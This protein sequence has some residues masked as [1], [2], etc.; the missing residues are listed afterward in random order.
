MVG[1]FVACLVLRYA[2]ESLK[3]K[4]GSRN[5]AEFDPARGVGSSV[6][7]RN[8]ALGCPRYRRQRELRQETHA[9]KMVDA[10]PPLFLP[11]LL[12][13]ERPEYS[14]TDA[15]TPSAG[16]RTMSKGMI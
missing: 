1:G 14:R 10:P 9:D 8:L 5:G 7:M 6:T 15:T 3:S 2:L 11:F 4:V 13:R 12:R 16:Q